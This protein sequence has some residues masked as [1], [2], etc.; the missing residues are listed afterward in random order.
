MF[1]RSQR[2]DKCMAIVYSRKD[3]TFT[4]HT[5]NTT[6][7][8]QVDPYGFLLH[9]YY[10]RRTQGCMEF[11]LNYGDRGFSGT[12]G[13]STPSRQYSMDFLPQELPTSGTGDYRS[14]AVII[15][16]SDG[17]DA[18]DFRF[19]KYE[20]RKGKY[21]LDGL[22]AVY[23]AKDEAET[24]EITLEDAVTHVRARLL[25]GVLPE[26]D[27]ITRALILENRGEGRIYVEKAQ[28][29]V[30]DFVSGDYDFITFNGRHTMERN[31]LRTPV[32]E[33]AQVISSR[34]GMSSHQHNCAAILCERSAN[35]DSGKAYALVHVYSG[36]FKCE[37]ER[38]QFCN[39]RFQM[40]LMDE[41]LRYPLDNG[42]SFTVPEVIMSYSSDGLTRLSQNVQDCIREHICR[43]KFQMIE[44][45]VLVNSW[46]A[47]YFNFTG[48]VL[49]ELA[50]QAHQTGVEMLVMDDG[51]F[52]SRENDRQGL[53]D[54]TPNEEKLG[55]TL[56]QLVQRIND[57]GM[58]F[59]IWVEPEAVNEYSDLYR[60]HPDW[61]MKIPGRDPVRARDQLILDLSRK[62]VV[63][64][65]YE[66]M[67]NIL[68]SA[69]IEYVK[70]DY[71]RN[72]ADV[73]SLKTKDQ[74]R[75]LY[76]YMLG[77]YDLL[78]RLNQNYPNV[79]IE[80]CSG[81]GGRFDAGMLYYTPQI[82]CSDNSDAIDRL[83]IQYGTSFFYPISAVGAHVSV[84]PNEQNGRVTPL[85]TRALV[86]MAGSFGY[87]FSFTKISD[88]ERR[89][90]GDQ[91]NIYK[92]YAPL[93]HNGRYFRLSSPFEDA[94]TA[95]EF[96]SRDESEA[97]VCVVMNEV[98]GNNP[99][100][101]VR[102]KGLEAGAMYYDETTQGT[103]PATVLAEVGIKLP[104][105][106]GEYHAYM[107]HL[108]KVNK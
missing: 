14:P 69:N 55:G 24:L 23:A 93:I 47:S 46:E 87:E 63:D 9:L 72:I 82:W 58:K 73:F 44:R 80:G 10:G 42:E 60:E 81:G 30:L 34:R 51:W 90:I 12:P 11:L 32:A 76:D 79:M 62:D 36:G 28:S 94:V 102:V 3:R 15:E 7:Q 56:G 54:W 91:I 107:Y 97:L 74:G 67:K 57:I 4:I 33:T 66:C 6:Y 2:K 78:E 77:L 27:I 45:P 41:K 65:L 61:A 59:G 106:A 75:V 92:K 8:M 49:V 17:S 64:Y 71:N 25:Y 21:G 13:N 26:Y 20:I 43:G 95:W 98:H 68:D 85:E 39:T 35:E 89:K 53:G 86:A 104:V 16:N 84:I 103:Y 100:R 48:D 108:V 99:T 50:E 40:G 88:E 18:C 38:D 22:P 70:W 83:R 31:F 37:A 101:Y 52:G 29:A 96:A 5:E 1:S 105:E 19:V